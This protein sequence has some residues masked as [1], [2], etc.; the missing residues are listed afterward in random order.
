ME[1]NVFSRRQFLAL[2]FLA[3][4]SPAARL[5]PQRTAA[6]AGS[7]GWVSPL[8]AVLP[9]ALFAL[10]LLPSLG[11]DGL[12]G[13]FERAFG[14]TA[15]R[16]VTGLYAVWMLLLASLCVRF[17]AE[18]FLA[19]AYVGARLWLFTGALLLLLWLILRKN[20]CIFARSC[21]IYML[22]IGALLALLFCFAAPGV[23]LTNVLP[24]ST[25][26]T[27]P[28]MKST[29]S[30]MSVASVFLYG[31]FLRPHIRAKS[32]KKSLVAGFAVILA[33]FAVM[34][35][36][37]IGVFSADF[38]ADM[39]VPFFL[40]VKNIN[41]IRVFERVDSFV[42]AFFVFTDLSYA[43]L[44]LFASR[45]AAERSFR[46]KKGNR[47]VLPMLLICFVLALSVP[48]GFAAEKISSKIVQPANIFFGWVIPPCAAFAADHKKRN[49]LP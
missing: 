32:G 16:A 20:V 14:P 44:M 46:L 36:L 2:M 11:R 9:V 7:A 24:V 18:R 38:T 31:A 15:G 43:G 47:I 12:D 21:E 1:E 40:L 29:L 26:D 4:I 37:I 22:A 23:K 42:L 17:Y 35:L 13:L 41:V 27:L 3:F 5:L 48:S 25:L 45:R 6:L 19:T 39:Q 33:V 8:L 28:L 30:V 34:D 10:L 49:G